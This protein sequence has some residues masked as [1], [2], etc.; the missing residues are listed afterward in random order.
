MADNK[1]DKYEYIGPD[2]ER[3]NE[4]IRHDR[5]WGEKSK[6]IDD[7]SLTAAVAEVPVKDHRS[8]KEKVEF[9]AV[10]EARKQEGR[11]R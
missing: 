3:G 8:A 1:N 2:G 7:E 10:L 9:I 4:A 6:Y 5:D 11:E